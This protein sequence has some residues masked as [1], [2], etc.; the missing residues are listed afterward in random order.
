MG[1]AGSAGFRLILVRRTDV[2]ELAG[3]REIGGT[4]SIRMN[5]QAEGPR[6]SRLKSALH[7]FD[8]RLKLGASSGLFAGSCCGPRFG[9]GQVS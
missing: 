1:A 7:C 9:G 2:L 6:Y 4:E 8:Y 5:S 3:V